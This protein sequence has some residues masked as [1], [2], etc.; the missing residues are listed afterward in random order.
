MFQEKQGYRVPLTEGDEAEECFA[1]WLWFGLVPLIRFLGV[2]VC[3]LFLNFLLP[4]EVKL[5]ESGL[6]SR[7]I[8]RV[9][10]DSLFRRSNDNGN[11]PI[12][13]NWEEGNLLSLA[14]TVLQAIAKHVVFTDSDIRAIVI[15]RKTP[16]Q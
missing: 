9:P 8:F 14:C 10:S 7:V 5:H 13:V 4:I 3:Y 2:V 16:S 6:C 1:R 15:G 11:I 12:V